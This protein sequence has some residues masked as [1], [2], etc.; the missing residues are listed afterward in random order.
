MSA[1]RSGS[2]ASM[3]RARTSRPTS[4][5]IP[6]MQTVIKRPASGSVSPNPTGTP[7]TP[8]SN[9]CH[10][11]VAERADDCRRHGKGYMGGSDW[12]EETRGD[13]I[14][15]PD[16]A[17]EDHE[18][19]HQPRAVFGSMVAVREPGRPALAAEAEGDPQGD[20]RERVGKVV[21]RVSEERH[22]AAQRHHGSL[23]Q[24]GGQQTSQGDLQG[25]DPPG[26][27]L[28]SAGGLGLMAMEDAH[29]VS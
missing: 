15:G 1:S 7:P 12:S 23:K 11:L 26:R 27:R 2:M 16:R 6:T 8:E 4:Q 25:P 3:N 13:L 20:T 29:S 14:A 17:R 5:R 9:A 10:G 19:D 24:R 28:R 18:E 22:A 21:Q